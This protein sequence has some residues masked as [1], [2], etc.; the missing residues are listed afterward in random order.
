MEQSVRLF[1]FEMLFPRVTDPKQHSHLNHN[2]TLD[3]GEMNCGVV[4]WIQ[5]THGTLKQRA[6]V[7]LVMD[8]GV[9]VHEK[10]KKS[11][12]ALPHSKSFF[13]LSNLHTRLT[14]FA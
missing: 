11:I 9:L 3:L 6:S 4:K 10:T 8:L 7:L 12:T 13:K 14:A 5:M 2:I 1:D